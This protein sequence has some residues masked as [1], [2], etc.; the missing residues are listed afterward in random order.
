ME[1]Y[2]V[3]LLD[4]NE[5]KLLEVSKEALENCRKDVHKYLL[6]KLE[7]QKNFGVS[8]PSELQSE[9]GRLLQNNPFG[10]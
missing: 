7:S 5:K 4:I 8:Q 10:K 9:V 2:F 6:H 1:D 3:D